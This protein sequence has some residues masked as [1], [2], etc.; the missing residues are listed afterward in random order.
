M[1]ILPRTIPWIGP[2][3]AAGLIMF[4][5]GAWLRGEPENPVAAA[6]AAASPPAAAEAAPKSSAQ[7]DRLSGAP[8]EI[9]SL[10]NLGA[11]YVDRKE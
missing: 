8:P 11:T 3:T 4:G 6:A 7:E 2:L 1:T 5:W 9:Q 10:F